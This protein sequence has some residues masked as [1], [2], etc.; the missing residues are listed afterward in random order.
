[1]IWASEANPI[2]GGVLVCL[3]IMLVAALLTALI[4]GR[5]G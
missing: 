4:G 5:R 1:M 2:G 3:L